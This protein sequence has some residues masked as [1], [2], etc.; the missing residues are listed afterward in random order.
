MI[1]PI[2]KKNA[3]FVKHVKECHLEIILITKYVQAKVNIEKVTPPRYKLSLR[4]MC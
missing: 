4:F 3:Y 1:L 2:K